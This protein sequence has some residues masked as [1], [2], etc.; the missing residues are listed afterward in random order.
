MMYTDTDYGVD[1]VARR[2]KLLSDGLVLLILLHLAGVI[3]ACIR[4]RENLALAMIT[5]TKR[6]ANK[7][8]VQ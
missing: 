1:W 5:G 2:H 3:L 7:E 8:D 6:A 4:H